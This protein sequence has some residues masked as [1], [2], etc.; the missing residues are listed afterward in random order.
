MIRD[1]IVAK[2]DEGYEQSTIRNIMAPLRGMF[3]Q[4]IED[5]VTEKNPAARIGKHNKQS[6]DKP[7]KKI[8]PL[9]RGEIQVLL[10]TALEKRPAW[11]PLFLCA[12]R[13]ELRMGELIALRGP[14]SISILLKNPSF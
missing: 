12:C 8:D 11:Y 5:G 3:F 13:T 14:I 4:A 2:K 10:K 7:R 1:L 9:A 6:K